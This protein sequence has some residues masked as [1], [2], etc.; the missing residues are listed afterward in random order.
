MVT[1]MGN[2]ASIHSFLDP[3]LALLFVL[4]LVLPQVLPFLKL[5]ELVLVLDL[6]LV[7]RLIGV[8][9][10]PIAI[11]VASAPEALVVGYRL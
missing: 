4:P 9:G 2:G 11:V 6:P 1:P 7:D 10:G 5:T 3:T 8:S